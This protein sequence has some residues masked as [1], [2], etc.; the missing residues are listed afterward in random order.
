MQETTSY[1]GS[2]VKYIWK[3]N[4]NVALHFRKCFYTALKHN[5]DTADS[6]NL[7]TSLSDT[8]TGI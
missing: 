6:W 2:V 4:H 1:P 7:V 3:T 8:K 5:R